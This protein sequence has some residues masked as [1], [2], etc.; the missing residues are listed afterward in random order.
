MLFVGGFGS[1]VAGGTWQN[2]QVGGVAEDLMVWLAGD[3][4]GAYS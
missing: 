1:V 4:S 2:V 3:D